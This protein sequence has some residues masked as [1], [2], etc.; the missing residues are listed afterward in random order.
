M[1]HTVCMSLHP[2]SV[3]LS[4]CSSS[5]A[6]RQWERIAFQGDHIGIGADN[7]LAVEALIE[8]EELSLANEL[9]TVLANELGIEVVG[10]L[11]IWL[12][13]AAVALFTTCWPCWLYWSMSL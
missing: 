9:T 4:L 11:L 8:E 6:L 3:G 7:A 10:T 12:L 5:L 1:I 2:S 13:I